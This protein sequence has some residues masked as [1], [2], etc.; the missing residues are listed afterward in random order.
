MTSWDSI[1]LL[2]IFLHNVSE[3]SH[4]NFTAQYAKPRVV[5]T[6]PFW[7]KHKVYKPQFGR[8]LRPLRYKRSPGERKMCETFSLGSSKGTPLDVTVLSLSFAQSSKIKLETAHSFH[9]LLKMGMA[10]TH[11]SIFIPQSH[12]C[13]CFFLKQ[14]RINFCWYLWDFCSFSQKKRY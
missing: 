2:L 6:M 5:K 4:S 13:V 14:G 10:Q 7:T 3:R 8:L 1:P 11:W 12:I 9:P